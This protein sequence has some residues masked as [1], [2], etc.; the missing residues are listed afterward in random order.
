MSIKKKLLK[1]IDTGNLLEPKMMTKKQN[2]RNKCAFEWS[3][4]FAL[5]MVDRVLTF[6]IYDVN[7]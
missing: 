5:H 2:K 3:R 4:V 1:L 7:Q 6:V